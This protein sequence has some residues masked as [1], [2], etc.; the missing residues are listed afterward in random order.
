VLARFKRGHVG[1][2]RLIMLLLYLSPAWSASST[3]GA[4]T[5]D[6]GLRIVT[7]TNP[8][9]KEMAI[10]LCVG[11]GPSDEQW[12]ST[13]I[14]AVLEDLL[15]L[16]REQNPNT[17]NIFQQAT[18]TRTQDYTC[19]TLHVQPNKLDDLLQATLSRLS[20]KNFS[21][22]KLNQAL[23]QVAHQAKRD[24]DEHPN[25]LLFNRYRSIALYPSPYQHP[26]WGWPEDRDRITV[27]Q[28]MHWKDKWYVGNNLAIAVTGPLP[29]QHVMQKVRYYLAGLPKH[30]LY[31]GFA[32]PEKLHNLGKAT[33]TLPESADHIPSVMVGFKVPELIDNLHPENIYALSV[34]QALLHDT[35]NALV[36]DLLGKEITLQGHYTPWRRY[37]GLF[38]LHARGRPGQKPQKLLNAVHRMIEHLDDIISEN[39]LAMAK[40]RIKHQTLLRQASPSKQAAFMGSIAALGLEWNR[41]DQFEKGEQR[42]SKK[43]LRLIAKRYLNWDNATLLV[44][45]GA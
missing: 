11:V 42:V 45:G 24:Q 40:Q 21:E 34:M 37:D 2:L 30:A 9:A 20:Q 43:T 3:Q 39:T 23:T 17:K 15:T 12:G 29:I 38:W 6:N 14:T 31:R 44:T 26:E 10:S 41:I 19:Q 13:G 36:R 7:E 1:S 22:N 32:M 4:F 28:I 25:R 35:P 18:T 27:S 5:L 33:L 16:G 8:Q